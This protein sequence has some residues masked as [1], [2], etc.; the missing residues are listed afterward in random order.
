VLEIDERRG[1]ERAEPEDRDDRER[2]EDLL[3]EVRCAEDPQNR[4]EHDASWGS[5]GGWE[6]SRAPDGG[7]GAVVRGPPLR[8]L[9]GF[10]LD[11]TAG[12]D[13]LLL[14]R[15]RDLVDRNSQLNRNITAAENL[16]LLVLAHGTLGDQV[17]DGDVAA[18]RVQL[19]EALQVHDLVLDAERIL[20]SAQLR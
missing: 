15:A 3:A 18:L 1:D 5:D 13:D 10:L 6:P 9:R 8:R 11:G 17:A 19:G 7:L 2:E 16:D 4:T 20:E 12:R 14:S